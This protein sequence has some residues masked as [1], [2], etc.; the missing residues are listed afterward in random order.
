MAAESLLVIDVELLIGV[1]LLVDVALFAFEEALPLVF[2][3][4]LLLLAAAVALLLLFLLCV[5]AMFAEF[6]PSLARARVAI[7][8]FF[9]FL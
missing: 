5:G 8:F 6:W 4:A 7:F 1:G 9:F 2:G 3:V